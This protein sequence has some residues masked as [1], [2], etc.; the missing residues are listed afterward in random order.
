MTLA[1]QEL[2][3]QSVGQLAR[4]LLEVIRVRDA[5]IAADRG[6]QHTEVE[7]VMREMRESITRETKF[8]PAQVDWRNPR[9][10]MKSLRQ[11][12]RDEY[13]KRGLRE[14]NAETSFGQLLRYGVQHYL[15]DAYQ[16]VETVMQ[17]LYESRPSNNRQEWYAPLWGAEVPEDVDAGGKFSDSRIRG[18]DVVVENKKVGRMLSIERELVDDDQTGQIVQRASLLGQRMRYKEELDGILELINAKDKSTGAELAGY[19]TGIGNKGTNAALSMAELEAAAIALRK[20]KDP[21]GNFMLVNAD[22]VA[23]GPDEEINLYKLLNSAYQP[24]VPGAAGTGIDA[25]SGQTGWTLTTN[26]LQGKYTPVISTFFAHADVNG[27]GYWYVMQAKRGAVFQERDPLE[28]VQENPLSGQAFEYDS[29]R[30]RVR[31]RYKHKVIE[32]RFIYQGK[33]AQ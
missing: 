13:R 19:T 27:A 11:Y 30:Y 17:S 3:E 25:S 4:E 6:R 28:V 1:T 16:Q 10:S 32:P 12:V 15:F 33:G 20:M 8:D 14:A 18:L 9:M 29:Y 23:A 5:R 7:R 31:R 2:S 26:W 22:T 21:L 24:A